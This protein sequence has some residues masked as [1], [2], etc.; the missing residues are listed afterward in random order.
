MISY[1]N[2][3]VPILTLVISVSFVVGHEAAK[4]AKDKY[5]IED[6]VRHGNTF[7]H[8]NASFQ[9]DGVFMFSEKKQ[10]AHIPEV[11]YEE[12]NIFCYNGSR[13]KLYLFWASAEFKL[14]IFGDDFHVFAGENVSVVK[15]QH[16]KHESSWLPMT[17]KL[18]PW[19]TTQV[20]LN[21]FESGCVGVLS[22][23]EYKM[24]LLTNAV[25]FVQLVFTVFAVALFVKA[26]TLCQNVI[27]HYATGVGFGVL[28]SLALI[29]YMIQRRVRK[30][31]SKK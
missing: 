30:T 5:P 10:Y 29:V 22:R 3:L 6:T 14:T 31:I 23:D 19:K 7:S 18:L 9:G 16:E 27:L 12:L 15:Q 25:N 17:Y 20:K 11:L 2:S 21:P 28:F 13:P 1:V 4:K 24:E 26:E 8:T